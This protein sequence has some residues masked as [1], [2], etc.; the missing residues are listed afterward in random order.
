MTAGKGA[1]VVIFRYRV[2]PTRGSKVWRWRGRTSKRRRGV[3]A[4]TPTT[5]QMPGYL[6]T[7]EM[8]LAIWGKL[9][10]GCLTRPILSPGSAWVSARTYTYVWQATMH[11]AKAAPVILSRNWF[12]AFVI[13]LELSRLDNFFYSADES[14]RLSA[15]WNI[16]EDIIC[17]H[18][19]RGKCTWNQDDCY[20]TREIHVNILVKRV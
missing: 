19:R 14:R 3:G 8:G 4:S 15:R 7:R 20:H 10:L 18:T 16:H 12:L 9:P 1:H 6:E 2:D 17:R 5:I 11:E 13:S